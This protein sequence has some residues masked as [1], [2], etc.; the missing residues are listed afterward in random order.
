MPTISFPPPDNKDIF[1]NGCN[2]ETL[3]EF[4]GN[5]LREYY[6]HDEMS[7]LGEIKTVEALE[8]RLYVCAG[9]GKGVLEE[10]STIFTFDINDVYPIEVPEELCFYTYYPP[11]TEGFLKGKNF[12]FIPIKLQNIYTETIQAYNNETFIL[13]AVGIRAVIEGICADKGIKGKN[14]EDKIN[15]LVFHIQ[16]KYV[17]DLHTIRFLG[18]DAAHELE[19]PQEDELKLAIEICE[20]LMDYLY[21]LDYKSNKLVKI[22]EIRKTKE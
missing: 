6:S 21:E 13:C 9:C 16:E 8:N 7:L 12:Q 2:K 18:N 1:C 19:T 5:S 10:I 20:S 15:R 11:S 3:H 17:Q 14:L 4:K 22:R